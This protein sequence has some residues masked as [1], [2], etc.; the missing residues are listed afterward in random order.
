MRSVTDKCALHLLLSLSLDHFEGGALPGTRRTVVT[1][2]LAGEKWPWPADSLDGLKEAQL[3]GPKEAL[4]LIV[5]YST[6]F[7]S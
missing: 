1:V 5:D 2:N 6:S 7:R 4:T 3:G